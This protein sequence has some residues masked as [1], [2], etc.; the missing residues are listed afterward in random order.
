MGTLVRRDR[1]FIYSDTCFVKACYSRSPS[2]LAPEG[3]KRPCQNKIPSSRYFQQK[4]L[5]TP[6][7]A[8]RADRTCAATIVAGVSFISFHARCGAAIAL[9]VRLILGLLL[10]RSVVSALGKIIRWLRQHK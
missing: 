10:Q 7:A 8:H 2:A 9:L 5:G 1:Q 6:R 3:T 4:K